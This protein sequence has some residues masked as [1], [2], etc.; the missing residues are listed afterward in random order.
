MSDR[1]TMIAARRTVTIHFLNMVSR[2]AEAM[3]QMQRFS[4]ARAGAASNAAP[5]TLDK[6]LE[7]ALALHGVNRLLVLPVDH[8]R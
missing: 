5:P 3:A 8:D 1:T 6:S 7:P 2:A 4:G